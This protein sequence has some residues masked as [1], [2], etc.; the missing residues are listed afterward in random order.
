MHE[1]VGEHEQR[2]AR[3]YF[4]ATSGKSLNKSVRFFDADGI[5]R[6]KDDI[7]NTPSYLCGCVSAPVDFSRAGIL[8]G[9][10]HI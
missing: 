3:D 5:T 7:P 1:P 10:N 2:Y 6:M 8:G 4:L 9:S